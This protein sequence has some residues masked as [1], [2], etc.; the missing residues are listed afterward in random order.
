MLPSHLS[1][2]CNTFTDVVSE[3]RESLYCECDHGAEFERVYLRRR[4]CFKID[5][6]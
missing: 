2:L 5:E 1:S 3:F 4:E 6:I